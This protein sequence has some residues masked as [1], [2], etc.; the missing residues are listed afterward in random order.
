MKTRAHSLNLCVY[1]NGFDEPISLLLTGAGRYVQLKIEDYDTEEPVKEA[2]S[3]KL[4]N[5]EERNSAFYR[6]GTNPCMAIVAVSL[7]AGE[8][9]AMINFLTKRL[10]EMQD[11]SS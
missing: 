2:S 8:I 6:A 10:V 9:E 7:E 3:L 11:E 4:C 5:D 1:P